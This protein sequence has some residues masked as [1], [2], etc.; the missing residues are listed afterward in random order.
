MY[1]IGK[2]TSL[3]VCAGAALALCLAAAPS[4]SAE[5][6]V[7]VL[8][9][10]GAA[11]PNG[12][13]V[14][15]K[16]AAKP[17]FLLKTLVT[18]EGTSTALEEEFECENYLE[19]GKVEHSPGSNTWRILDH[20]VEICEGS[21][22]LEEALIS[23]TLTLS[24]PNIA[25][26]ELGAELFRNAEAVRAEE[27]KQAE[28]SEPV[29]AREPLRCAYTTGTSR[30]KFAKPSARKPKPLVA[31]IK[32]KLTMV[33][34]AH[35]QGCGLKKATWKGGFTIE[36]KGQ[37]VF[38]AFETPPSVT[39]VNPTEGPEAEGTSVAISGSG[40]TGASSVSFGA[41]S[42]ASF[43]VN[44]DSSIT[45]VAPNGSGTVDVT[46][47]TPVATSSASSSDHYTFRAPPTVTE[48][49]PSA[50]VETG[51][52]EVKIKGTHFTS[53]STVMFGT[54]AATATV[55]SEEEITATSPPGSGTV[56][57]TVTTA[58]GT[59]ATNANDKYMYIL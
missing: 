56:D 14:S 11:L 37:P 30:G 25:T 27:R 24:A 36:Y 38:A 29:H 58:G 3:G 26:E 22:W 17:E 55:N 59:S 16:L 40:F 47:T 28:K 15:V 35:S 8:K 53:G 51:G 34:I 33:P 19:Q 45:A 42:A 23:N 20:P 41:T 50:G 46:V 21:P 10:G 9:A 52:T 5:G 39:G 32:G 1:R 6:S 12:A 54:S 57:V 44:S 43:K 4:A 18:E 31:K 49:L 2:K 13:L 48:V 7:F